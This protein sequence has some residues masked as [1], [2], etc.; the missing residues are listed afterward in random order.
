MEKVGLQG[1]GKPTFSM[2]NGRWSAA[3]RLA[4]EI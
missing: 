1:P 2:I 4:P 3:A